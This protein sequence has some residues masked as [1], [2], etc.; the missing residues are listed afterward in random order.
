MFYLEVPHWQ[1]QTIQLLYIHAMVHKMNSKI[2][3]IMLLGGIR[4]EMTVDTD[5]RY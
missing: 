2:H 1:F 3:R 5:Q 4:R